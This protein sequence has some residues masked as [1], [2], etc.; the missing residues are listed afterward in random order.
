MIRQEALLS[1]KQVKGRLADRGITVSTRTVQ[2]RLNN[3]GCKS[4]RPARKPKLTSVMKKKRLEFARQFVD[5][6]VE[7]WRKVCFSDESTFECQTASRRRVWRTPGSPAP[8]RETVKH[9][10]KVMVWGIICSKGAGRLHVVEG[11]MEKTQ[12]LHVMTTKMLPQLQEWFPSTDECIFMHDSAPCHKAKVITEFLDANGI[13][14]LPWPGNSPDLNPIENIW[15]IM[16][17]RL[18]QKTHTTK[19]QLISSIIQ[20]WFHDEAFNQMLHASIDSMP[21]RLQQ[22]IESKG[23]HTNY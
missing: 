8:V 3:L 2:R 5:K 10:T 6:P 23:G 17:E 7:F 12:Y 20:T 9:P 4:V 15:G 19:N 1:A 11:M 18:S 22:V 14:V 13:D 16:K 21:R